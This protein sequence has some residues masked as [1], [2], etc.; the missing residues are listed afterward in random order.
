MA[1]RRGSAPD[2]SSPTLSL[3]EFDAPMG[4]E[5]KTA[6][7]ERRNRE[8]GPVEADS[9]CGGAGA[10]ELSGSARSGVHRHTPTLPSA[11]MRTW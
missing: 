7:K 10:L 9:G 6:N 1:V 8:R 5:G 3:Q 11:D 4:E 2:F